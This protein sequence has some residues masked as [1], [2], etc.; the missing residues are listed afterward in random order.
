[1]RLAGLVTIVSVAVICRPASRRVRPSEAARATADAAP[2]QAPSTPA[3]D[4]GAHPDPTGA[5]VCAT[6]A[7]C[8]EPG[9]RGRCFTPAL[10][11]QYTQAFRDCS[12]GRAWRAAHAPG[13]CVF[14]ECR[15]ADAPGGDTC[16]PGQRCGTLDMVPFPQRVCVTATCASDAQCRRAAGGRCASY[17]AGGHCVRGGWACS[18][19]SDPC[20]PRDPQR[21]CPVRRG[22]LVYCAPR[23][24]RFQCVEE[25]A[26]P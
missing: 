3:V 1:M 23:G 9:R 13:T 10:A 7:D 19:A 20:A 21:M 6:D 14:D 25:P 15:D 18:Y 4:A 11:A 24:G 12:E 22:M 17:L 8:R 16:G 2:A 5:R 26:V